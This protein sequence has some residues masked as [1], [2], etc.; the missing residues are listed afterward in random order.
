MAIARAL[1]N[2]PRL[3]LA[4]EP[5]GSLD[6][7]RGGEIL[8][9][10]AE[11]AREQQSARCCSSPTTRRRRPWP[12]TCARCA[13][14]SSFD[15]PSGPFGSPP[16]S[17]GSLGLAAV[18]FSGLLYLYGRRLRT[19]PVQE[20]LAGI[21]IA[22]GV[23][24]VFAVQVA[25]SSITDV[26]QC[27]RS[28]ASPGTASLQLRA[29]DCDGFDERLVQA[30][31]STFPASAA[32]RRSSTRTRRSSAPRGRR[33]AIDLASAAPSLLALDGSI[34]RSISIRAASPPRRD[35]RPSATAQA[36]GLPSRTRPVGGQR[37]RV[38][39]EVRGRAASV[40]VVASLGPE[41]VG[42]AVGCDGGDR[43]A[44]VRAADRPGSPDA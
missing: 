23:A 34:T 36:L 33:V 6:S 15:R 18:R 30:R 22:I 8:A 28:A 5:T 25:N 7:K 1:V 32:R 44:G 26:L 2:E 39:L 12:T 11:L 43:A 20:L 35:P 16:R 17:R 41:T 4:D 21:G 19:R 3:I 37:P 24:L 31:A 42:G 10:L 13:T 40:A 9:L 29:R 38:Q 27:D 14:A